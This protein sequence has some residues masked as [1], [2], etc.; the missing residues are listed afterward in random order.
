MKD[1]ESYCIPYCGIDIVEVP[2][3]AA[4]LERWGE[5]FLNRVYTARERDLYSRKL[6]SLAARFAA[7]EAVMKA[8]GTG[9]R[10]VGWKEIE[11]VPDHRGKPVLHLYGRAL[12]RA[13]ELGIQSWDISL[14][15]SRDTAIA[16]VVAIALKTVEE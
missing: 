10:G 14:T 2:R 12:N 3:I 4:A 7:K 11:V 8:L 1:I 5:R 13:K 9:M 16:S 15:H 6:L